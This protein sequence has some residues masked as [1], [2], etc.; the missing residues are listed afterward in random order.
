VRNVSGFCGSV[1]LGFNAERHEGVFPRPG[2]RGRAWAGALQ[3]TAR[4]GEVYQ[5]QFGSCTVTSMQYELVRNHPAEYARLMVRLTAD[6]RVGMQGGGELEL[7]GS[8]RRSN[9]EGSSRER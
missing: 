1:N 4:P 6:G 9:S 2:N 8:D 5:F 7:D 3:E